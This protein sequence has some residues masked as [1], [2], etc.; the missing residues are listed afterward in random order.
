VMLYTLEGSYKL[1]KSFFPSFLVRLK[2]HIVGWRSIYLYALIIKIYEVL[3]YYNVVILVPFLLL[4]RTGFCKLDISKLDFW[5]WTD[6]EESQWPQYN[7][8]WSWVIS[9][10]CKH[11]L[12]TKIGLLK[13]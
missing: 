4:F 10:I 8:V 2:E 7:M 13:T 5:E 3:H 6:L 1:I 11:Y 9:W 12:H